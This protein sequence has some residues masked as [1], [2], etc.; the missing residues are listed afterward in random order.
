MGNDLS[1][2]GNWYTITPNNPPDYVTQPDWLSGAFLI[3][4]V[5]APFVI[6]LAVGFFI[7][8]ILKI[9][10][11]L[12]GAAIVALFV[13]EYYGMTQLSDVALQNS[14]TQATEYARSFV[15]FLTQRLSQITSKGVSGVAGFFV[16]LKFG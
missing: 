8:K 3:P 16:G 10:L 9:G 11:F 13:T 14:A 2:Q 7:K 1:Q 12:A 6:G 4:N 5:A 15:D